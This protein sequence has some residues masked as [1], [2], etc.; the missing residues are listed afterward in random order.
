MLYNAL[1]DTRGGLQKFLELSN[2]R[3]YMDNLR[4]LSPEAADNIAAMGTYLGNY[5]KRTGDSADGIKLR[6]LASPF[7]QVSEVSRLFAVWSGRVGY[8]FYGT[9][10]LAGAGIRARQASFKALLDNPE[11]GKV[12]IDLLSGTKP[13]TEKQSATLYK[14]FLTYAARD[15]A[16]YSDGDYY[17]SISEFIGSTVADTAGATFQTGAEILFREQEQPVQIQGNLPRPISPSQ[18]RAAILN[19]RQ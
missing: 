5:A 18:R 8:T 17:A 7:N 6:G 16:L 15:Y 13:P 3:V 1:P 14:A 10:L 12:L 9:Q 19:E 11:A 4:E 2:D